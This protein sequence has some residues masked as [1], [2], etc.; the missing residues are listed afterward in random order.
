MDCF[1]WDPNLFMYFLVFFIT[2]WCTTEQFLKRQT[3][4]TVLLRPF[5]FSCSNPCSCCLLSTC[6]LWQLSVKQNTLNVQSKPPCPAGLQVKQALQ[7][8]SCELFTRNNL[9]DNSIQRY[10]LWNWDLGKGWHHRLPPLARVVTTKVVF[11]RLPH[12]RAHNFLNDLMFLP[13]FP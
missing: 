4:I 6:S 5:S 2:S 13:T 1:E 10:Y 8:P 11:K 7:T 9:S 12:G 3:I